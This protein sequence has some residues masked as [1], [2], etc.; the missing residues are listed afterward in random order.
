[1]SSISASPTADE[2]AESVR[3]AERALAEIHARAPPTPNAPPRKNAG[4]LAR[5][6]ADEQATQAEDSVGVEQGWGVFGRESELEA[7]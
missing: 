7:G 4:R 6:H 1:M 2:T 3:R 5:W